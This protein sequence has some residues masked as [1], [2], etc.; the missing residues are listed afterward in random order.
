[1]SVRGH[2]RTEEPLIF[3]I[4]KKGKRAFKLNSKNKDTKLSI[5]E[6]YLRKDPINLPEVSEPELAR[7]YQRLARKNYSIEDG[8]YP[9]GSCT[10]KYNPAI[11]EWVANLDGFKYLNPHM[12]QKLVQSALRVMYELQELLKELS[13]FDHVT[14]L[15]SAGAQGEYTGISMINKYFKKKGEN[16]DTVLIPD[17]A[18]GTNPASCSLNGLKIVEIKTGNDGILHPSVVKEYMNERVAA[19]MLTNPNTLG[20]F[21]R[22]IKTICEIVHEKGGLVYCDG[23]NLNAI[24]A[25]IKPRDLGCDVMH[26]NLHKTFATPH[27]GGGPGAGPVGFI[28]ILRDF[29]PIP[30][31]E[32]EDDN[33]IIKEDI[34]HTIGRIRGG[35][36]N[37]G[38][39]LK[40]YAYIREMGHKGLAEV[41]H[42]AVLS[43]NYLRVRL[44]NHYHIPYNSYCMH[45]FVASDKF[46]HE[47]GVSTMQIAKRLM[48][49]GFHPPT[50]YFPLI[51][52]GAL[53]IEPTE[54]ESLMEL[55]RFVD[56]MISIA[57]EARSNPDR[58][59]EFPELAPRKRLNETQAARHP[60]LKYDKNKD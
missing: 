53:M 30:V 20:L 23:A 28:D 35:F 44:Q 46:Q 58:F 54:T 18:H 6:K 29:Q 40:A 55:D 22:H 57:N 60:I 5:P 56:A 31:I 37:F 16:R 41:A 45:E 36:G 38:V 19:L 59:S 11:N 1:M 8:L 21:E 34:P 14:L 4:S 15:P 3:E 32:K 17:T 27:G 51:V 50:V 13:G 12:P 42:S 26:F 25:V 10:M 47:S 9:L 33:Y 39:I 7:H 49:Y 2:G 43:A 48:D 52:K 24:V